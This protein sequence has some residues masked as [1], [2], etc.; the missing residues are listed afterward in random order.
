MD[1]HR[2]SCTKLRN[3]L[4]NKRVEWIRDNLSLSDLIV[5]EKRLYDCS[6]ESHAKARKLLRFLKHNIARR[7]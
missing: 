2:M 6:P 7:D 3:F 5:I 4:E 1:F